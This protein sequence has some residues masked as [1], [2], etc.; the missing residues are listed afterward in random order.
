[1]KDLR[2]PFSKKEAH[3]LL[4]EFGSPLY[5]Y[6]GDALRI[7]ARQINAAFN[8]AKDYKN[9]FAV[10][11]TPT[12]KILQILLDEGMGLD[13]SSR[14]ELELAKRLKVPG[15]KIFYTSNNT[16][17]EDF[18]LALSLNAT[19]NLDDLTQ[20]QVLKSLLG[21][22]P[23]PRL[24]FRYNPGDQKSGNALIGE[25]TSAKYGMSLTQLTEAA[26]ILAKNVVSLGLHTM[27]ASNELDEEY[28]ADTARILAQALQNL[29]SST[30]LKVGFINLGGGF[31]LNYKPDQNEFDVSYAA[32]QIRKK[33]EEFGL[34]NV[35]L[36]TENG[37]Y[38]TGPHGYLLSKVRYV[39]HK[40]KTYVGLDA[41]MHNL[42][43]PGMYGAY[44]HITVLGKESAEHS[45][46]Y[47]VSGSLCENNDKFAI[48]RYLPEIQS[49]DIVAIHDCG[50]HGHSMGFNY[51]G[52][53]KSPEV[54]I[55]KNQPA[56]LARRAETV[57]DYLKTAIF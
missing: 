1:M 18:E 24:A 38:V 57:E 29:E 55:F 4:S 52:L 39:M 14:A 46:L 23:Y 11:A 53:L 17:K 33:I 20:V 36:Y 12:P 48:D 45:T 32:Q 44:H 47:D 21:D 34:Q 31:G 15:H 19:I 50:A 16:P 54:I 56:V 37:R 26:N 51:N 9:F 49:G 28:F 42:M 8:W 43:R 13:C 35:S 6:D 25:P 5:V 41:S 40:H 10:K 27:V 2:L 30:K 3:K 7:K 22:S